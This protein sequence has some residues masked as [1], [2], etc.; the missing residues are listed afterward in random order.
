MEGDAASSTF[1]I[2]DGV[3]WSDGQPL[4]A[5]DVAFTFNLG[6]KY[7][8]D[9]QGRRLEPTP[10]APKATSVD[11]QGQPGGHHLRGHRRRASTRGS[12]STKILPEHIYGTV[13]DPTKYVDK[14]PVGTGPFKVGNY[15][16]RRLELVRR[17]DYWQADKIKVQKLVLEGNF[18]ASQ[19]A[20]KLRS[21]ELDAYWGEIPNPAEDRSSRPTPRTTT[22]GTRRTAP[23]CS[24]ATSTKAPFTT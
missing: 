16:G 5:K 9:R 19:A 14:T 1:D 11:R 2:R 20:L 18:D 17:D 6:K 22:S 10:S 12:S 23:P 8:A 13:G 21:G 3:K 4:T 7:P 24:A 15:N